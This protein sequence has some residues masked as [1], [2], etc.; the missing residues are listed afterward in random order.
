MST[1]RTALVTGA[2]RGIGFEVARRLAETGLSV[3]LGSRDR[4]RGS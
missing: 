3:L 2:N 1:A 4:G